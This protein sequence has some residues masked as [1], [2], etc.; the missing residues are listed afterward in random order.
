MKELL[1]VMLKDMAISDESFKP[2]N[3]WSTGMKSILSD[4]NNPE[5]LKKFRQLKSSTDM[6]V[7]TYEHSLY[8]KHRKI[9]DT[10]FGVDYT[11]QT[12]PEKDGL[13]GTLSGYNIAKSDHRVFVATDSDAQPKVT[14]VS[15]SRGG[16]PLEQYS[17]DSKN[18]SRSFFNYLLGV[19]FLKNNVDTSQLKSVFEIGGGF[20]TLGEILLKA[21]EDFFYLNV[22]IPPVS[23]VSTHYLSEVFGAENVLSYKDSRELDVID[24]D[25]LKKKYKC[26]IL[27]PWQL[28]KLKGTVDLFVNFMSFQEME[29]HIVANYV[30]YAEKHT[31]SYVLIRNSRHG[32]SVAQGSNK[33]GVKDPTKANDMYQMFKQFSLVKKDHMAFGQYANDFVSEIACLS[34]KK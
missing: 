8:K 10:V 2:T 11:N 20:G 28:P 15:E 5:N 7:P 27:C 22:D 1:D 6:F 32:K 34:K 30:S 19:N 17:F 21:D 29:P 18:Y 33:I 31:D 14:H 13:F 12:K 25:E 24:I 3:F 4:L 9:I 23:A 26:V 16:E